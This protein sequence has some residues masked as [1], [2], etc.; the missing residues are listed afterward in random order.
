VH[1][2]GF[3]REIIA[4]NRL[5]LVA[6]TGHFYIGMEAIAVGACAAIEENDLLT[7]THRGHGHCIA[8]GLD[9]GRMMAEIL[10]RSDG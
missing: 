7:S 9:M 1:H 8:R 3:E 2:P 5:G 6:G 10:S 4:L